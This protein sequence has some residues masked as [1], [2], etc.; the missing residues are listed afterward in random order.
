MECCIFIDGLNKVQNN[1]EGLKMAINELIGL[2]KTKV[3]M[4][5]LPLGKLEAE[6]GSMA[7]S[8]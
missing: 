5:G 4:A 8:L 6:F 7:A 1:P 3:C 2:S